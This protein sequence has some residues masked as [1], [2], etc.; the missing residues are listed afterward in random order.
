MAVQASVAAGPDP[1]EPPQSGTN[2]PVPWQNR[3]PERR[4]GRPETFAPT[5]TTPPEN[6][7]PAVPAT[8]RR[9]SPSLDEDPL[10]PLN[11]Q[12]RNP[13][14]APL[15]TSALLQGDRNPL[16][17]VIGMAELVIGIVG[18]RIARQPVP[19]RTP[20]ITHTLSVTLASVADLRDLATLE[21]NDI[22]SDMM[23]GEDLSVPQLVGGAVN[24]LQCAGM[25]IPSARDAGDNLVIF[26]NNMGPTDVIDP[27]SEEV[28]SPTDHGGK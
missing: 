6:R 15:W 5:S 3:S 9:R 2:G 7:P 21:S 12:T 24:W 14:P 23:M 16:E 11:F 28:Y 18:M 8:H 22:T 25:L 20:R 1:S 4:K 26:V 19:I 10:Q 27:V 17:S 13:T